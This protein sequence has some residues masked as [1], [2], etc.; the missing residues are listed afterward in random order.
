MLKSLV[1]DFSEKFTLPLAFYI[2]VPY[3]Q[4]IFLFSVRSFRIVQ[5]ELLP[6]HHCISP[7]LRIS[8]ALFVRHQAEIMPSDWQLFWNDFSSP[9]TSIKNVIK[10]IL[11]IISHSFSTDS[12]VVNSKHLVDA[13][14]FLNTAVMCEFWPPHF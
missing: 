5:E 8:C 13:R 9:R 4:K 14:Q 11:L 7:I 12:K 10:W 3:K 2:E 1:D 6:M